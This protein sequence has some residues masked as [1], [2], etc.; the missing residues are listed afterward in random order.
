VKPGPPHR[1]QV[2]YGPGKTKA[3]DPESGQTGRTPG[4]RAQD[5]GGFSYRGGLHPKSE[6]PDQ[7][8]SDSRQLIIDWTAQL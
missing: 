5:R 7:P 4:E 1:Q 2:I 8:I 6:I 3:A